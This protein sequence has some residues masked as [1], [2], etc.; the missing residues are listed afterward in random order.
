MNVREYRFPLYN[1]LES[2]YE[3]IVYNY[4]D[5][6]LGKVGYLIKIKKTDFYNVD[7]ALCKTK[8]VPLSC[9]AYIFSNRAECEVDKNLICLFELE[10]TGSL[11][12][13]IKQTAE[14]CQI[15]S[16]KY[17]RGEYCSDDN[18]IYSVVYDGVF[19]IA[20]YY[21]FEDDT[22][23]D[24]IG[25]YSSNCGLEVDEDIKNSFFDI[26][27]IID[28]VN[29]G[30]EVEEAKLIKAIK[31]DLRA[32]N[33]LLANKS[34]LMTILAAVYGKTKQDFLVDALNMLR[35]TPDVEAHEIYNRWNLFSLKIDYEKNK[36]VVDNKLYAQAKK[37]WILSQ[38]KKMDLYG[39]IYEELVEN[40]KKQEDGEFYTSRHLI[41]PIISSVYYKY[42]KKQWKISA[43]NFVD[44]IKTK[45]I[46]DPFCG[47]GGFLY[48]ILKLFKQEYDL[49]NTQLNKIAKEAVFGFDKN[50]IMAA[51]LNLYL[52]GDGRTNL[53]QVQSSINWQNI[54]KYEVKDDKAILLKKKPG[55]ERDKYLQRMRK[56]IEV[57]KETFM[58]FLHQ[59]IDIKKIKKD[60]QINL[61]NVTSI[62]EF[63]EYHSDEQKEDGNY[64]FW[65]GLLEEDVFVSDSP[66]LRYMYK[67]FVEYSTNKSS[68]PDYSSFQVELGCVDFMA[69]NVPY[70]TANDVRFK[71]EST[72]TLESLALKECIDLLRPSTYSLKTYNEVND[73]W[74]ED[75]NG[76]PKSN[77][78]GGIATIIIPNR[79][80][81]G[82]NEKEIRE[83]LF[84]YCNVLSVVKLPLYEFSPYATI[85]TFVVTIQKKAPFEY[86]SVMQSKKCF[87]YI[88]DNDGRANSNN[89]YVTN[90]INDSLT[91]IENSNNE[92]IG[93]LHE[94]LHD[95]FRISIERYP[96]GYLS[97]LERAWIF[98]QGKTVS[99]EWN[100]QR[101]SS[102]W[103]G[104]CWSN[105]GETD[106]KW[107]FDNLKKKVYVKEVEKKCK[108]V[109]DLAKLANAERAE[110]SDSDFETQK[111][112]IIQC[113]LQGLLEQIDRVSISVSS[114]GKVK[115]QVLPS[116]GVS[117][118]KAI[119]EHLL[120]DYEQYM[121]IN[122]G[123][124]VILPADVLREMMLN[125]DDCR[126]KIKDAETILSFLDE[127]E[128]MQIEG[129]EIKFYSS[130]RYEQYVLVPEYYLG[131]TDDFMSA[132]EIFKNFVRLRKVLKE[133]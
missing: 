90:L 106:K 60:F 19:L 43:E 14:Y 70:G 114:R 83:Y 102:K 31:K 34:A 73:T 42:L 16:R 100:Q 6:T 4:L 10:S 28:S 89:R 67:L 15:L 1:G 51:Y 95:D 103:N 54:W 23:T 2:Q 33:D 72:G 50:D 125:F 94:Y 131:K 130:E 129:D 58:C 29:K 39:F 63:I 126:E 96:E 80:F 84:Q 91:K 117:Y 118:V 115:I 48:E 71:T 112:L 44:V 116:T 45:K 124:T 40:Q 82:S 85:Q 78:D 5:E 93:A 24:I 119:K 75:V 104:K 121:E 109:S 81:E 13:G 97:K 105:I 98:G 92:N 22:I 56:I 87:F 120:E 61:P 77:N 25:D 36:D 57:H 68:V 41:R 74:E 18:G 26:F 32:S 107:V 20:Y 27:P 46:L 17:K 53:Y 62:E 101:Y 128:G 65:D 64:S 21:N 3:H 47:S 110:F 113:F 76:E 7:N 66:I 86:C 133:N 8:G 69:T 59:L 9:D 88:V 122:Q 52:V 132:D 30:E 38:A 111:E 35:V 99:K 37:L 49:K 123:E 12:K 108:K 127:V 79:I 11:A 55:E